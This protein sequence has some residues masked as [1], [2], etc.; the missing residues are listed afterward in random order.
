[1]KPQKLNQGSIKILLRNSSDIFRN[2]SIF[3]WDKIFVQAKKYKK[4]TGPTGRLFLAKI[5]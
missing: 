5:F 3:Y 1:V 4:I 2:C